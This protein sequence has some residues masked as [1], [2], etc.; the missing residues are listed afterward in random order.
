MSLTDLRN[1]RN[2]NRILIYKFDICH[3]H[4]KKIGIT[5]KCILNHL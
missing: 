2:P 4:L 1:G 5:I 3:V